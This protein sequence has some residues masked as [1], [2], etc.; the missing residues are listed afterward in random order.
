MNGLDCCCLCVCF[1]I[2]KSSALCQAI[3]R[4]CVDIC[5]ELLAKGANVNLS[6]VNGYA[7]P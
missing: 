5:E 7:N 2:A 6:D 1:S 3:Q 4:Q